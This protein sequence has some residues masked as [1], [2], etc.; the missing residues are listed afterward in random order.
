MINFYLLQNMYSQFSKNSV[1]AN[2]ESKY[3]LHRSLVAYL[4]QV[5]KAKN[6]PTTSECVLS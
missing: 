3:L 4:P 1:W 2:Q 5:K 6:C